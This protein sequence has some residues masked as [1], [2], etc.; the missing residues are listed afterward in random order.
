MRIVGGRFSGQTLHSPKNAAIRPTSDRV[1]ESLFNVLAHRFCDRLDG[2][3]V[4]DLF[5]G[6]GALGMEALSRGAGFALF[7][8][9]SIAGRSVI[10]Q[11]IEKLGLEGETKIFR[12]D[13][14]RLGERQKVPPFDLV[15]ADPP[16]GKKLAEKAAASLLCGGWLAP[17]A[18]VVIEENTEDLPTEISGFRLQEVKTYGSTSVGYFRAI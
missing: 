9:N 10:R 15:F 13:A 8:D 11:N 6:T 14:T 3:R 18:L 7:V 5:A 16:Y 2:T 1:R 17:G 12:R 4:L